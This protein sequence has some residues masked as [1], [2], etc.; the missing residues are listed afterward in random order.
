[1]ESI[2]YKS[3]YGTNIDVISI[4]KCLINI[5]ENNHPKEF[6]SLGFNLLLCLCAEALKTWHPN[7]YHLEPED[8]AKM[9]CDTEDDYSESAYVIALAEDCTEDNSDEEIMSIISNYHYTDWQGNIT[10]ATAFTEAL[11]HCREWGS[12]YT[13]E[14]FN[15]WYGII[16]SIYSKR[17]TFLD[18]VDLIVADETV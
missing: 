13:D 4:Y 9:Q 14:V 10:Y 5:A 7:C 11:E 17:K 12:N 16:G 1:M 8:Y 3:K 15:I 6:E 2:S 18:S